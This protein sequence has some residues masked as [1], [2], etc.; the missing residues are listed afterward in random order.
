MSWYV[1]SL[2]SA[3]G[4]GSIVLL[5]SYLSK[6][7]LSVLTVNTWFWLTTGVIFLLISLLS[8]S[9]KLRIPASSVKWFLLLATIAVVTNI[10]SVKALQIGPNSGIVRSVQMTQ[11]I[12]AAIGG[13]LLLHESVS[14]QSGVGMI[15]V[16]AGVILLINK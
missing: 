16:I 15:M 8:S 7:H 12:V 4:F 11:V 13:V 5:L 9:K 10:L 14:L 6:Q 2:L 1:Y 3:L